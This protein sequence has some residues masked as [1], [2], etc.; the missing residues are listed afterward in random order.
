MGNN[1]PN[2]T[3]NLISQPGHIDWPAVTIWVAARDEAER[4]PL[5]LASLLAQDYPTER[6]QVLI[7]ND[8][9]M[10]QTAEIVTEISKS[11]PYIQLVDI[12]NY[13]THLRSKS[14]VLNYLADLTKTDY[15][16]I[17][18][19]DIVLPPTWVH[20]MITELLDPADGQPVHL[21]SGITTM[22]GA[23]VF[24][25]IQ[26][27][28]WLTALFTVS[29]LDKANVGVTALGN[30]MAFDF[31]AYQTIG[32]YAA[33]PASIVEDFQLYMAFRDGGFQTAN[34]YSGHLLA[35]TFAPETWSAYI[36]Q[37]VRWLSGGLQTDAVVRGIFFAQ[38]GWYPVL[39]II[40]LS[41]LG[42]WSTIAALLVMVRYLSIT[43]LC[44]VAILKADNPRNK[45]MSQFWALPWLFELYFVVGYVS[46]IYAYY[47][48]PV[49]EW[50]GR[51]YPQK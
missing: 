47:A 20:A 39:G 21:V 41:G 7:G 2:N 1:Q 37:R 44:Y 16:L 51:T 13:N 27:L 12:P 22:L 30:N 17:T 6:L 8:Q 35:T 48:N 28:D 42:T 14:R 50:K 46:T 3:D 32:G 36:K 29:L 5:L 45:L 9:S 19:A 10:D 25:R 24:S 15:V 38:F 43:T 23:S 31:R 40:A 11:F 26:G 34:R 4:L 49:V 18:D 33:L